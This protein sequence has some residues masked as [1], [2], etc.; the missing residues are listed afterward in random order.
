MKRFYVFFTL[1]YVGIFSL[2][3]QE[4]VVTVNA[5]VDGQSCV[6]IKWYD[7]KVFYPEGINIYRT[8]QAD[9][10]RVKLNENPIKKGNYQLPAHLLATDTTL[11]HYVEIA[12]KVKS[13]DVKGFLSLFL[14]VKTFESNEFSKY[15]GIM[16]EDCTVIFGE[17]YSYEI[18]EIVGGKEK[19][20]EKSPWIVVR[21]VVQHPSPD[22]LEVIA[23]DMKVFM[24]WKYDTKRYWGVNVYRKKVD[25][26]S[27]SLLTKRPIILSDIPKE[28]GS[29]S[30]PEWLFVD[31]SVR[32]GIAYTY[33]IHGVDYF[34]RSTLFSEEITVTPKDKTP[35]VAPHN[36][37]ADV[38]LLDITLTWQLDYPSDDMTG[39]NIYRMRGRKGENIRLN[40]SLLP[41]VQYNYYD[42]V[43]EHGT[44]IYH[45]A[46]VDSSGNEGLSFTAV[47][48]VLDIFPPKAPTGLQVIADTGSVVL[49]WNVNREKDLMGYRIYRTVGNNR[50]DNYVLLNAKAIRDTLFID[51]LPRNAKNFFFYKIAALDSAY[52]MSLYSEVRSARMPDVIAPR[53]P[54]IIGVVQEAKALRIEWLGNAESDLMG[55]DIYRFQPSDSVGTVK[56][57]NTSL[58]KADMHLFTDIWVNRNVEYRY[59]LT[60]V[61]STGNISAPSVA[62]DGKFMADDECVIEVKKLKASVKKNGTVT[63]SW[64]VDMVNDEIYQGCV[65]YRKTPRT[66]TYKALS[67]LSETNKFTDKFEP[68]DTVFYYQVRAYDKQGC[69]VKSESIEVRK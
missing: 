40:N 37:R 22:S 48:E 5:S 45:V 64:K 24:R 41:V 2:V 38:G 12:N 1:W 69:V 10:T 63:I 28:D 16:Y 9:A 25:E 4:R 15:A 61:D 42:T 54:F 62:Y 18:C 65:L 27:F 58:I 13:Q 47:G 14:I 46:S 50:D 39:Y 19:T 20:I 26:S 56:R 32:N 59:Y 21:D 34:A 17:T 49:S 55:Y 31:T 57:L 35:P 36:V 67:T 66:N 23:G 52:N 68:D 8:S 44:Y 60:A 29:I 6:W 33:K 51:S 7:E 53:A 11:A 43:P 30:A 3:A